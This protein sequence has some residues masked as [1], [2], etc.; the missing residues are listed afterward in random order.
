MVVHLFDNQSDPGAAFALLL[1]MVA[2]NPLG[3]RTKIDAFGGLKLAELIWKNRDF[4]TFFGATFGATLYRDFVR[5]RS[6]LCQC[7]KSVYMLEI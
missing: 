5:V 2:K 4:R 7:G 6:I 3:L 1:K